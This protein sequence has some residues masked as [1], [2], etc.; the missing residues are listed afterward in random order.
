M[1]F[2]LPQTSLSP[3][4]SISI[5]ANM[6]EATIHDLIQQKIQEVLRACVIVECGADKFTL[7]VAAISIVGVWSCSSNR[8]P[9]S[10]CQTRAELG[11][12]EEPHFEDNTPPIPWSTSEESDALR[13]SSR[14]GSYA[15]NRQY[16]DLKRSHDPSEEEA[17]VGAAPE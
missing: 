6:E 10:V 8:L 12:V 4:Q 16:N 9:Y 17:E 7:E 2:S 3:G 15:Q 1:T 14:L 5:V 11:I 13:R